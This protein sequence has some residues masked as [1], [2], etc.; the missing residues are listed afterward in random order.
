MKSLLQVV[1]TGLTWSFL[2]SLPL[3]T[4]AT[5]SAA[6][7]RQG[8][9]ERRGVLGQH[10]AARLGHSVPAPTTSPTWS[11]LFP[12]WS[13]SEL[14]FET[15]LSEHSAVYDPGS[16]TMIVFGG[17]DQLDNPRSATWL[18]PTRTVAE[19]STAECGVN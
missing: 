7:D 10:A 8:F 5:N 19:A 17:V 9:M 4:A 3:I 1:K 15:L 12:S 14:Y 11:I 18:N 13:T 16:N 6:Q 2:V